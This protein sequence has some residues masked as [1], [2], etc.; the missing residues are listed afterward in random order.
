MKTGI[1]SVGEVGPIPIGLIRPFRGQPRSYFDETDLR[2]LAESI[3][4]EGQRTPAW[5]M[6]RNA[7]YE[8]IAGERRFRACLM[9]GI[10]TLLCE[11]REPE[12]AEHQ[13]LDSVM[14]NF[15]RK[16]CTLL[17]SARAVSEVFRIKFGGK[18]KWGD[19]TAVEVARVFARSTG[20]IYQMMQ[21][22]RL[23]PK[24]IKLLEPPQKLPGQAAISLASLAPDIQVQLAEEIVARKMKN[25]AAVMFIKNRMIAAPEHLGQKRTRPYEDYKMLSRFLESLGQS[26]EVMLAMSAE[27]R[28]AMFKDRSPRDLEIMVKVISQR[29]AQLRKLETDLR[30][31]KR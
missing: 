28:T 10:P 24:V 5:V 14:E 11:V 25:R 15:G 16:E 20:W 22:S 1:P 21:I 26:A 29:V 9:V 12:S 3:Q 4:Q 17:E 19:R 23:H 18:V 2:D 31:L 13:Y 6:P 27:R 30:G 8:L 7:H